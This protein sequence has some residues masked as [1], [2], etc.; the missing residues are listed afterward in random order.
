LL[1]RARLWVE[2][3]VTDILIDE[4]LK[5]YK[6]RAPL[7]LFETYPELYRQDRRIREVITYRIDPNLPVDLV[8]S[9]MNKLPYVGLWRKVTIRELGRP[10][11]MVER[12]ARPSIILDPST[13]KFYGILDEDFPLP[14]VRQTAAIMIRMLASNFPQYVSVTRRVDHNIPQDVLEFWAEEAMD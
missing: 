8:V 2:P 14:Q 3:E 12:G 4:W 5:P 1:K 13:G 7:R 9:E 11:I 6:P 10:A